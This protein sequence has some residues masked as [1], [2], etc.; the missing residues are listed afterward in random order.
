LIDPLYVSDAVY[1]RFP[2]TNPQLYEVKLQKFFS[3]SGDREGG[4]EERRENQ[5]L[6]KT[7]NRR[8]PPLKKGAAGNKSLAEANKAD[9]SGQRRQPTAYLDS[10]DSSSSSEEV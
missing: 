6:Q 2:E 3:G 4:R 9:K 7:D 1:A 10:S 8:K 5:L